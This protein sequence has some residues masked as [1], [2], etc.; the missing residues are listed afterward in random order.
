MELDIILRGFS[1]IYYPKI[2]RCLITI[3]ENLLNLVMRVIT[4]SIVE[5][6]KRTARS[7]A[8]SF[9]PKL[10]LLLTVKFRPTV[11]DIHYMM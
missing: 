1:V 10:A 5:Q 11:I 4:S 8:G 2:Y 3:S 7:H 6:F 9:H